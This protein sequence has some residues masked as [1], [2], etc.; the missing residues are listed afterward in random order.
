MSKKKLNEFIENI[1]PK[2]K[3]E[4]ELDVIINKAL[5]NEETDELWD[6]VIKRKEEENQ[7]I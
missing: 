3:S 6:R 4:K 1:P 2:T 7:L 5:E